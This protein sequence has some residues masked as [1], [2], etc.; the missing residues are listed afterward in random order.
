MALTERLALLVTADSSQAVRSLN[1]VERAADRGLGTVE[2]RIDRVGAGMRKAGAIMLTAGG[3]AAFGLYRAGQAASE[4]EQAVGGS[5]AVFGSYADRIEAV[6]D[7]AAESMG[8]SERAFRESTS[9]IGAQLKGFGLEVDEAADKSIEL[10]RVAADLAATFGGST[11]EAVTALAAA[12]RG[13]YD[14]AERFGLALRAASVEAKAVELGLAD[15]SGEVDAASKAQAAYTLI[16]EQTADAQGQF[17][18]ELDTAA[19]QQAVMT[20]QMEDAKAQLGNA[21]LPIMSDLAG[22]LSQVATGFSEL[23]EAT[24]GAASKAVAY[25]TAA[26]LLGGAVSSVAGQLVKYRSVLLGTQAAQFLVTRAQAAGLTSM[27]KMGTAAGAATTA[28]AALAVA[29]F[30]HQQRVEANRRATADL[31]NQLNEFGEGDGL[32]R[33][34]ENA[35]EKS[36]E[37]ANA[38][39][40]ADVSLSEFQAALDEGGDSYDRM[41]SRVADGDGILARALSALEGRY[42]DAQVAAS[43]MK[44]VVGDTGEEQQAADTSG[45]LAESV[46]EVG[47]AY[48]TAETAL[49]SYTDRLRAQYDPIFALQDAFSRQN[50]AQQRLNELHEEGVFHGVEY[51]QA[52][53]DIAE[54]ALGV[55]TAS[56]DVAFAMDAGTV[57]LEGS[58]AQL[59][60]W[61]ADGLIFQGQADQLAGRF[62]TL[63]TKA[64]DF[65]GDYE[66]HVYA[67]TTQAEAAIAA[68]RAQLDGVLSDA[69]AGYLSTTAGPGR[70]RAPSA[71]GSSARSAPR[72]PAPNQN[73]NLHIDG[74]EVEATTSRRARREA[75]GA[76]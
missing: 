55:T 59:Q 65:A 24:G 15:A 60:Q 45:D 49:K 31:A 40:A 41:V 5:E 21:V 48:E 47:D 54:A 61:V 64:D 74:R 23:D 63:A 43:S 8:L 18:R 42:G 36:P 3:A 16:M 68:L 2:Q 46:E 34:L 57:S 19:G 20:A 72:A 58:R 39:A 6:G 26:L 30:E 70:S 69:A 28:V 32:S 7:T 76:F 1:D 27:S 50:D 14:P 66:A 71:A 44:E 56:T 51:D 75:I 33:F 25:T 67:D 13:E 9:Q 4:L 12:F 17:S 73:F 52:L 62:D 11:Q 53:V 10:T 38:L 29:H 35:I 22:V 37:L